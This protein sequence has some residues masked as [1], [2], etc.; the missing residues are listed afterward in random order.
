MTSGTTLPTQHTCWASHECS[1]LR[2]P[3]TT[4]CSRSQQKCASNGLLLP[5]QGGYLSRRGRAAI[6]NRRAKRNTAS[7]P[8]CTAAICLKLDVHQGSF[9]L[10]QGSDALCNNGQ[11]TAS[12][13]QAAG[14][15]ALGHSATHIRG[16]LQPD[17][18]YRQTFPPMKGKPGSTVRDI[19]S[20]SGLIILC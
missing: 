10:S 15:Q 13:Q 16:G 4:T 8:T 3:A 7:T 2:L 9:S 1:A 17:S 6:E 20:L 11:T 19:C 5:R 14:P 18:L 12:A